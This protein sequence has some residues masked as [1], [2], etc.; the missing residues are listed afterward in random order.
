MDLV[1]DKL[2]EECGIFG[3]FGHKEASTLTQLGLFA[4]QHRGQEACGI[5]SA[6]GE[7]LHQHRA[8]GLVADVLNPEVLK[9]LTG[10]SAIGHTRYSTTGKNTIKEVQPFSVTCQHGKIAVCHNG[11]LP[12]ADQKRSEL[13][14]AGAIFSSTSDTETI[15]HGIARTPAK[16][17]IEAIENVLCDTEGA[18]CLLFL[19]PSALIAV[20]DPRGFRPLVLGKF[21]GAWCVASETCAFDLMDAEYI[22]EVEPGEMLIID[23]DGVHS[24]KPFEPKA[25]AVCTFEHVYFSRPDSTIFG[26]SVNESR[27]K[28]GKQLAI[29]QP[30]DA[31][32]VVPVPDSGV[33]AAIGFAAESG[34]NFRQAIIRNHYVG[35]TFIEPSQSI[36]SF[37]VRLKLNPIKDLINGRRVILVD[38]S[39]VRGTTSKKIVEMVRE[40]GAAEV[41]MRISCPPTAHSCYYG[42]D[43]PHRQDLIAAKMIVDEVREY[44][45]ADSLGYLSLEGMLEA[46][47]LEPGSTCAACWTGKYPTLIANG[48]AA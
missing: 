3:I 44:I 40:A 34:I 18:Y 35:R 9:R 1:L 36:R 5:V 16:T 43:T 22:R 33:A 11:N 37:G 30:C 15:L 26:K 41:H 42:V 12:F 24:S 38:D 27:H 46:I 21:Q 6:E 19:T 29:E 31:D 20:R 7:D 25:H 4:L 14:S 28:M 2:H 47:G 45:G 48:A 39:I 17:A 13:E 8:I 10:S 32:L 23:A